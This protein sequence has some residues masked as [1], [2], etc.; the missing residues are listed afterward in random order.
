MGPEKQPYKVIR[1]AITHV[2]FTCEGGAYIMV[3]ALRAALETKPIQEAVRLFR[4]LVELGGL[5]RETGEHAKVD[6]SLSLFEGFLSNEQKQHF[7]RLMGTLMPKT[8]LYPLILEISYQ[9]AAS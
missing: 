4:Q 1:V 5:R 2:Q 8:F 7:T 6:F 3:S 9:I